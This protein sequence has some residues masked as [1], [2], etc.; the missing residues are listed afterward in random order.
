MM[1]SSDKQE[2]TCRF[3][4]NNR[5]RDSEQTQKNSIASELRSER[6]AKCIETRHRFCAKVPAFVEYSLGTRLAMDLEQVAGVLSTRRRTEL[7]R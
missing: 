5:K 3:P 4:A 6:F 2:W 7:Y 1:P